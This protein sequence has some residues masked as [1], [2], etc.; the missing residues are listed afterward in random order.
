M[1]SSKVIDRSSKF[2]QNPEVRKFQ[3][4]KRYGTQISLEMALESRSKVI[5]GTVL[6]VSGKMCVFKSYLGIPNFIIY[7]DRPIRSRVI[8]GKTE[9]SASPP[10]PSP[11]AGEG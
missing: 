11:Y 3:A 2:H 1:T 9:L 6:K 5:A 7:G 4:L 10:A 8:L